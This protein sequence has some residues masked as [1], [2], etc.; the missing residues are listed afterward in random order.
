MRR[1]F[2]GRQGMIGAA[3]ATLFAASG[4]LALAAII[5][6]TRECLPALRQLAKEL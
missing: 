4:A 3:L 2:E 5:T 6:T 1:D